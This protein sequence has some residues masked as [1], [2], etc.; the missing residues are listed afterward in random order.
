[1]IFLDIETLPTNDDT[2]IAALSKKI[3]AP[4][5]H[6]KQETIDK[7]ME[8]NKDQALRDLIAKTSFD[9][10]YGRIA[11]IAWACDDGDIYSTDANDDELDVITKFY[12]HITF[13]SVDSRFCGHNLHGFDLPFLKHRSVILGIKP[14]T[15][16]IKAMRARQWDDCVFDTMLMWSPERDK[17]VSMDSLCNALGINGKGDFNGSMVAET[18]QKDPQKVVD[19]CKDDVARTREI[20]KRLT[21][22]DKSNA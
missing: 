12:D 2:V 9:G 18:W 13:S 16:L 1:M 22:T 8:E 21:F 5:T 10:M 19:Y 17:R 7:W 11:C 3:T 15:E 14:P 4:S 6:R 20:Y